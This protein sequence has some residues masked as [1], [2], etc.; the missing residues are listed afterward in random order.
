MYYVV[1]FVGSLATALA[2]AILLYALNV[3][4][5]A[6]AIVLALVV[7]VGYAASVSVVNAVNPRMAKPLLYGAVTGG[8]HVASVLLVAVIV[9]VMK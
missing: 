3:N 8:Y 5:I 2:T 7:G 1:P 9:F 4:A 6:D